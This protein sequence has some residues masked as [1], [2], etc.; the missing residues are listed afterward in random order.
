ML[1]DIY[2]MTAAK[3]FVSSHLIATKVY[4]INKQTNCVRSR[5]HGWA[6]VSTNA[7]SLAT[8]GRRASGELSGPRTLQIPAIVCHPTPCS[9]NWNKCL[10][11]CAPLHPEHP[12]PSRVHRKSLIVRP[13]RNI[14]FRVPA[15]DG[16]GCWEDRT[17][18]TLNNGGD[19]ADIK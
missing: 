7:R 12:L 13:Y 10:L 5:F 8:V 18:M 11:S 17:L 1:L 2:I 14:E 6:R 9:Q 15:T 19:G 16:C 3:L 4:K